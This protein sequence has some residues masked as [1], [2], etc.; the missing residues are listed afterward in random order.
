MMLRRS[1]QKSEEGSVIVVISY[2]HVHRVKREEH[3]VVL[4]IGWKQTKEGQH[5][6]RILGD[7]SGKVWNGCRRSTQGQKGSDE[8]K[9]RHS[10]SNPSA[11]TRKP[12]KKV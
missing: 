8:A 3:P 10:L 11:A 1:Q 2:V 12:K 7:C 6:I 9:A 5:E 4:V